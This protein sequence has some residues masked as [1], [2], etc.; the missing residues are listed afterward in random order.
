MIFTVCLSNSA[1]THAYKLAGELNVS[2]TTALIPLW[3]AFESPI[4]L[5]VFVCIKAG[6][7]VMIVICACIVLYI[8]SSSLASS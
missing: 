2:W 7:G 8:N 6:Y 4:L 3:I 5:P 1:F